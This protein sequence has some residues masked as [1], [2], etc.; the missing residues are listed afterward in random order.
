MILTQAMYQRGMDMAKDFLLNDKEYQLEFVEAEQSNPL[1]RGLGETAQADPV[2]AVKMI[3]NVDRHLADIF[4][5]V[6][7]TA[8][9]QD[10]FAQVESTLR[11]NRRIL[12][13]GCGSTER[14]I[15][16]QRA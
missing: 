8:A 12:L 10:F 1:T 16:P 7:T 5:G 3:I 14:P 13:S 9:F 11:G 15:P 2:K 6:V 4:A